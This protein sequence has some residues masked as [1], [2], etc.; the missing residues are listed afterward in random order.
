[1]YNTVVKIVPHDDNEVHVK[2]IEN[3][4]SVFFFNPSGRNHNWPDGILGDFPMTKT[5]Q[6]FY[7][8]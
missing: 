3:G 8:K 6:C 5:F 7:F 4:M 1:M 2:S